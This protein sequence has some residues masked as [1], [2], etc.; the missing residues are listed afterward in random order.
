[1][2]APNTGL[3]RSTSRPY[4]RLARAPEPA[5]WADCRGKAQAQA[6]RAVERAGRAAR[7]RGLLL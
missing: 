7:V 4:R 2:F 3:W 1:M 5:I 6:P